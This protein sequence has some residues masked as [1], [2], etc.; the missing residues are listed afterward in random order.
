MFNRKNYIVLILFL[1]V[2]L[3]FSPAFADT[4]VTI[5]HTNDTHAHL[6]PFDDP[7]HG[8]NC[9]GI[10]RRA[11]LIELIKKEGNNPLILDAGDIFQGTT[12]FTLFKG[13]AS[14]RTAKAIGIDATTMGNHE[15]DLGIEHLLAM[16]DKTQLKLL[17]S[18]VVWPD[19]KKHVFQPYA[20]FVRNGIKIGVIGRVGHDNW[21]DC[22]I[23][24][25]NKMKLLDDIEN[26]RETAKRI[27]P[28][29]DLLV[30]ISHAEVE[31]DRKL[32]ASVSEIDIVVG[33]HTHSKIM[34]PEL[35]KH[36]EK[37]GNYDN[38]LGGTLFTE[39]YEWGH[40]LGRVDFIFDDNKKIK[41]WDGGLIEV[42]PEHEAYA[43]RLVQDLV[44]YYDYRRIKAINRV[45]AHS[46]KGL[47]YDKSLRTKKMCPAGVFTC[48]SLKYATNSDIGMVNAKGVRC[49]IAAGDIKV[50]DIHTML[51]FD[52]T[53]VV[54]T[55]KGDQLQKMFDH[56]AKIWGK[57][58]STV[59]SGVTGELY[60]DE[61]K[62]K[63]IKVNGK[64]I[65]FNKDYTIAVTSFIIDGNDGGDVFFAKPVS[66]KDS[67]I[68]MRDAVVE[69]MESLKEIP[70]IDYEPLSIVKSNVK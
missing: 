49:G 22:N 51:P 29:V 1:T 7:D 63:N 41:S 38:G 35:I 27:R 42:L 6:I 26:I 28:Y 39:A 12:F 53:V 43:P 56:A 57:Q 32:A 4:K 67:G 10:V 34:K 61:N 69:Y 14:Y 65:D 45:I 13:E 24:V 19:G 66:I 18:N 11:G 47:P 46:E 55:L 59:F 54:V 31:N 9:G 37:A 17:A 60:V 21:G 36:N 52:N 64:P 68:I 30:V 70:T 58:S 62:A 40:Y 5:L 25:T 2:I 23:K 44:K 20:V 8:T 3:G 15:L 16:L 48:D 50:G 33:G